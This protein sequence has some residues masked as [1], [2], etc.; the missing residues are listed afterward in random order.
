MAWSR[1]AYSGWRER[2]G[3]LP[4]QR[5]AEVANMVQAALF[6]VCM[7]P[8]ASSV[9]TPVAIFSRTVSIYWLRASRIRLRSSRSLLRFVRR[10]RLSLTSCAILLNE[11]TS[12]PSSS[13][14]E[15]CTGSSGSPRASLTVPRDR[16]RIG[17]VSWRERRKAT[18]TDPKMTTRLSRPSTRE[19][20]SLRGRFRFLSWLYSSKP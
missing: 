19:N 15:S 2:D 10:S 3:F 6:M 11:V 13:L 5:F 7:F 9:T 20:D 4:S 8:C 12:C 17:S 18:Q 16:A 14:P 1:R